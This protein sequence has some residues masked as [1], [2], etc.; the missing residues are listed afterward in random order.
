MP[1]GRGTHVL[2]SRGRNPV[3]YDTARTGGVGGKA[4]SKQ[5]GNK[6]MFGS[7]MRMVA[8]AMIEEGEEIFVDYGSDYEWEGIPE[9][10]EGW[11]YRREGGKGHKRHGE[12]A[13]GATETEGEKAEGAGEGRY[14]SG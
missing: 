13:K 11:E 10:R 5:G 3:Y 4:N 8:T 1:E 12:G 9:D 6:A 14:G 7:D 2:K